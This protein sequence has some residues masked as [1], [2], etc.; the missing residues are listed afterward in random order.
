MENN[1]SLGTGLLVL[2]CAAGSALIGAIGG[3]IAMTTEKG[4]NIDSHLGCAYDKVKTKVPEV[5]SLF[6]S[7]KLLK[8]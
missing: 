5:S 7:L 4:R 3:A 1:E 8:K 6:G 2:V